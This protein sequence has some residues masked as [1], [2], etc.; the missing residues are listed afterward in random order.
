MTRRLF[1]GALTLTV[2]IGTWAALK[3]KVP[4]NVQTVQPAFNCCADPVC[5]PGCSADCPP[6]CAPDYC[7]PCP[8][9]P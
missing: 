5:P 2:W 6:D 3:A 1:L 8:F 4:A 9:C 7:P